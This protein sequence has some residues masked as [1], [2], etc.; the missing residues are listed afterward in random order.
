MMFLKRASKPLLR[1]IVR[2][3]VT[4]TLMG[5]AK[6]AMTGAV[7]KTKEK[8]WDIMLEM[9]TSGQKWNMRLWKQTIDTQ[10]SSWAMYIPGVSSSPEVKDMQTFKVILEKCTE[11]ELEDPTKITAPVRDRL[12]KAS[13]KTID[14]VNKF[15]FAY[16]QSDIIAKWLQLKKTLGEP[17]PKSETELLDLQSKDLR[18]ASIARKVMNPK[19]VRSGRGRGSP[20]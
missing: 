10:S 11:T 20:F 9:M 6:G 16:K 4:D 13:N 18:L 14:E 12:A 19:G 8:Q 5:M 2:T 3:G 17:L 1:G 15:M 7:E